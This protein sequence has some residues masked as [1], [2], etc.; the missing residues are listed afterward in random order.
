MEIRVRPVGLVCSTLCS[1]NR[2]QL[3]VAHRHYS[4]CSVFGNRTSGPVA[5]SYDHPVWYVLW[6]KGN[7][8]HLVAL[9]PSLRTRHFEGL[10]NH[11][12]YKVNGIR[13]SLIYDLFIHQ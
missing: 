5:L 11:E 1:C 6:I 4:A 8:K 9:Q 7:K 3:S 10:R 2:Y 12:R 13:Q